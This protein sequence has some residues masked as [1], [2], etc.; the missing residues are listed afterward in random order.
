MPYNLDKAIHKILGIGFGAGILDLGNVILVI[1][2]NNQILCYGDTDSLAVYGVVVTITLLFQSLYS[3]V[4]QAIQP[5]VS[6]NCGAGQD[7]RIRQVWKMSLSTVIAMGI[8]FMAIGELLPV[9]IVCLF[10]NVTPEVLDIA[11]SIVRP[12]FLLILFL[13][14]TVLSTYHLQ[15]TMHGKMSMTI[16]V[17]RSVVVSGLLLMGL[18]AI[19][20]I[21]GVWLVLPISE[22]I[23]AIISLEYIYRWM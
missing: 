6:A 1:L 11:P 21:L 9:Q 18:P 19:F 4:G 10:M 20:D 15:S 14:I 23:V 7:G 2:M 8:L 13:G 12:Y 5:I 3:G 16:A 22:L 17:L